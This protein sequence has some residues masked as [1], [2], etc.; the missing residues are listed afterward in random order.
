MNNAK[1]ALGTNPKDLLGAK[2]VNLHLVPASSIIYQALA[3][4]DGAKKYGP[5]N[6]RDNKVVCTI[7]IDAA[8]RHLQSF[9]DGEENASDSGKPHLGHAL[10]SIGI[11]VDA[12][13]TGNLVDNRPTPGA[14]ARLIEK[15]EKK[16][17][18]AP[19]TTP[20]NGTTHV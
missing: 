8:M 2:K 14:A 4:E 15:W 19:T 12:I 13:E 9:L 20:T 16:A 5:Y 17:P 18:P 7:Y 1:P 6:W 11:I 10:A 3:M